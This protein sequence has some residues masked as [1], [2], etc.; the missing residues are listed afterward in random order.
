MK[1]KATR[2][3]IGVDRRGRRLQ[4]TDEDKHQILVVYRSEKVAR[5]LFGRVRPVN[6]SGL[7]RR[8]EAEPV[9]PKEKR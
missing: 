6:I 3:W 7:R 2:G 4:S 9:E 1:I 8:P 5:N